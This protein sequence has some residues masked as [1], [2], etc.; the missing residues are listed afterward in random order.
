MERKKQETAS[1]RFLEKEGNRITAI[2]NG[3][4]LGYLQ[5]DQTFERSLV[6]DGYRG[7]TESFFE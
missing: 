4:P 6:K 3:K 5:K 7:H 1:L 2:Q